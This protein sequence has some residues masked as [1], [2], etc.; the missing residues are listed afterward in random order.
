VRRYR[1][2]ECARSIFYCSS[3]FSVDE[4]TGVSSLVVMTFCTL[5]KP[6]SSARRK[7]PDSSTARVQLR[8][9]GAVEQC[10]AGRRAAAN[11][12]S[13]RRL[14]PLLSDYIMDNALRQ[15]RW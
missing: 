2:F 14:L 11:P 6:K 8:S 10:R 5:S 3:A 12:G 7:P 15:I 13:A 9:H 4:V 1:F